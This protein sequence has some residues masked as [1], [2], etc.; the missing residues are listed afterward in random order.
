MQMASLV[1][2][3]CEELVSR[4]ASQPDGE[5][6]LQNPDA[7]RKEHCYQRETNAML[8]HHET[9]LRSVF[10]VYAEKGAG[11]AEL[12]GSPDLMSAAQ[13]MALMKDVGFVREVGRRATAAPPAHS[14]PCPPHFYACTLS[15][16]ARVPH[17]V[18]LVWCCRSACGSSSPSLPRAG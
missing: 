7:F 13:W 11:A 5:S 2:E 3:F 8:G 18:L 15:S 16:L 1:D 6:I 4:L 9:T 17:C 12:D 14:A 10:A